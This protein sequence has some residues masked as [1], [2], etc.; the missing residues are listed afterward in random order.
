MSKALV[1]EGSSARLTA[2]PLFL[3]IR[4]KAPHSCGALLIS[5]TVADAPVA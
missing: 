3:W 2:Q 5:M 4:L 1:V